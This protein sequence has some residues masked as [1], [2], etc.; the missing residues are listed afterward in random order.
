[1]GNT[2]DGSGERAAAVAKMPR[3]DPWPIALQVEMTSRCNL[4]CVMCPLTTGNTL[5]SHSAGHMSDDLWHKVIEVGRRTGKVIV[6]GFGEPLLNRDWFHYLRILEDAAIPFSLVTNATLITPECAAQFASLNHLIH[7]N[8]SLDSADPDLYR[9]IRGGKVDK[10]LKGIRALMATGIDEHRVTISSVLMEHNLASLRDVPP[11]LAGMGIH[12]YILQGL[13]DLNANAACHRLRL[14][15][16]IEADVE[17]IRE[18][19]RQSGV[20]CEFVLPERLGLE[21]TGEARDRV[22]FFDSAPSEEH[23]T[24]RCLLPWELP[25]VDKDGRVYPCC[26]ASSSPSAVAGD[27]TQSSFGDIWHGPRLTLFREALRT[28]IELPRICAGCTAVGWGRHP[29][30]EYAADVLLEASSLADWRALRLTV[31]NTGDETW[32]RSLS[33]RLA[34]SGPRDRRSA[35]YHESWLGPNRVAAMQETVVGPGERATYH[36][37]LTPPWSY[38]T[39]TFQLVVD[40]VCWLPGTSF[41]VERGSL[42][43]RALQRLAK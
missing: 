10:A 33:P 43:R 1:M 14:D 25:Y 40:G 29:L 27:L 3:V 28:G 16:L 5:S 34:T 41:S 7:I 15:P 13:V 11:L 26:Y 23:P 36:F 38:S 12:H 8:I 2:M 42:A 37:Q 30:Q 22:R 20:V 18:A 31:R 32:T 6:A 39:E 9:E 35:A 4:K 17:A 21:V 19:G 24:K